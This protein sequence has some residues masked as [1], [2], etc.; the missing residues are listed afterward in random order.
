MT[1]KKVSAVSRDVITNKTEINKGPCVLIG[2][3]ASFLSLSVNEPAM[4]KRQY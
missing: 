4:A 3:M 1:G 2:S